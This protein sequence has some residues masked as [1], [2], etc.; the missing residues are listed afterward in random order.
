MY[1]DVHQIYK[2]SG[3]WEKPCQVKLLVCPQPFLDSYLPAK[4]HLVTLSLHLLYGNW[5]SAPGSK[6]E[7]AFYQSE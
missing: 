6:L 1:I 4:L 5:A 3:L 7:L 2:A